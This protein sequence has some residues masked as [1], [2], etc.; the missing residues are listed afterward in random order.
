MVARSA[1]LPRHIAIT[2]DGNGRWAAARG[3]PRAAGHKAGLK[4]VRMCV[5]EC[6]RL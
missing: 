4:P 6:T 1:N 3:V 2:M 5:E